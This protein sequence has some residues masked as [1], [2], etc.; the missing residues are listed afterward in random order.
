MNRARTTWLIVAIA[1]VC[2]G[3]GVRPSGV[4]PGDP[5]PIGP[6]NGATLMFVH[7]GALVP[8]LRTT[9]D[10]PSVVEA[11]ELLIGGPDTDEQAVGLTSKVPAN[12]GPVNLTGDTSG[13]TLDIAIDPNTLPPLAVDQ[14][15]CTAVG[16]LVDQGT[17]LRSE[18]GFFIAGA[19][20][21]IGPV[22]CPEGS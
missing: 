19:G 5:A 9:S 15:T 2:A 3:C 14:L 18:P 17:A 13:L 20:N 4:I 1:L 12:A 10:Q 6:V 21:R 16:A 7:D 22:T 8:S 11:V